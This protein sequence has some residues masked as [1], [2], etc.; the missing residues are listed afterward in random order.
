MSIWDGNGDVK[1]HQIFSIAAGQHQ[2][3]FAAPQT[4]FLLQPLGYAEQVKH[5]IGNKCH[6]FHWDVHNMVPLLSHMM[7][8]MSPTATDFSICLFP[9]TILT[10]SF[11]VCLLSMPIS[12]GIMTIV[13]A[14]SP[15]KI[16][17]CVNNLRESGKICLFVPV[18]MHPNSV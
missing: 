10:L 9:I 1:F 12:C 4:P 7:L 6:I 13:A 2:R 18:T 16:K 3:F 5:T 15:I 11:D 8:G 17:G 14:V